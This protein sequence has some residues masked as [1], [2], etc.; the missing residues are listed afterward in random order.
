MSLLKKPILLSSFVKMKLS[1][2]QM[3]KIRDFK[4]SVYDKDLNYVSLQKYKIG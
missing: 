3:K 2:Y 4:R 1:I